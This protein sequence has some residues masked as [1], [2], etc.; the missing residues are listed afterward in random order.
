MGI[1]MREFVIGNANRREISMPRRVIICIVLFAG[2]RKPREMEYIMASVLVCRL[3]NRVIILRSPCYH[4]G[5]GD[6]TSAD[7]L[8]ID[9]TSASCAPLTRL[10]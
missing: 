6:C 9:M 5:N 10:C 8:E 1:E 2:S 4:S 3:S 7:P